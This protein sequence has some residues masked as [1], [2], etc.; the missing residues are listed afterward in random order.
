MFMLV[1]FFFSSRRRHTSWNC[2]WSSDVCSS[3]LVAGGVDDVDAVVAPE[4]GGGGGGDGDAA[5]ALLLHPVHDGGALMDFADLVGDAGVEEDALGRGG[6][7]GIDVCHDADVAV[8]LEWSGA[9]HFVSL[10]DLKR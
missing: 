8:A 2:D 9:G 10:L 4:A 7:A 6:L 1:F 5:L 3:D